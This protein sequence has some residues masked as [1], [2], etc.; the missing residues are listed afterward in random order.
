MNTK[1]YKFE[2][3]KSWKELLILLEVNALTDVSLKEI[4]QL[5]KVKFNSQS[6]LQ[7][8]KQ[9]INSEDLDI[10]NGD[11][12]YWEIIYKWQETIIFAYKFLQYARNRGGTYGFKVGSLWIFL[13]KNFEENQSILNQLQKSNA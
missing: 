3:F 5:H 12:S 8:F 4:Y 7:D 11:S 13:T 6:K 10:F 2:T 9:Q 1:D